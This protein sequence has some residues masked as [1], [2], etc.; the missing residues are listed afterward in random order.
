MQ[1]AAEAF[2]PTVEGLPLAR[3]AVPIIGNVTAGP[4]VEPAEIRREM[5][6]HLTSGVRWVDS[7][8]YM[9]AHGVQTFIEI[10]PKDVLSGLIRRI[11]RS[12]CTL[13][14]GTVADV[15]TLGV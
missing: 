8:R 10:G 4:L 9:V 6:Q 13:H 11:D 2:A 15:E 1:S 7:V 5:L 12:V 3:A 14:I